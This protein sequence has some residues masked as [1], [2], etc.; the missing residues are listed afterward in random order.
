MKLLKHKKFDKSVVTLASNRQPVNPVGTTRRYSR[1]NKKIVD[2]PKP[3]LI[4]YDNKNMG[5]VDSM[6]QNMWCVARFGSIC[7]IEKT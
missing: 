5:G 4:R 1:K 6:D 3:F 2:V 7:T